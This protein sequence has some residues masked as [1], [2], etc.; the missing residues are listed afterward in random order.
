MKP[1]SPFKNYVQGH[2]FEGRGSL[3]LRECI[4]HDSSGV[5]TDSDMF[6]T[7]GDIGAWCVKARGPGCS[8]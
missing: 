6:M 7:V 2:A 4:R 5:V 8:T 1:T 3:S